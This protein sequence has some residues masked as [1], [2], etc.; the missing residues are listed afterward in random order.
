MRSYRFGLATIAALLCVAPAL[1]PAE[2]VPGDT[3]CPRAAPGLAAFSAAT[4]GPG[5]HDLA[6]IGAA[7]R[8]AAEEYQLCIGEAT[9]RVVDEPR[10]NYDRVKAAYFLLVEARALAAS[11]DTKTALQ[12]AQESRKLAD[13]VATWQPAALGAYQNNNG[14]GYAD[15]RTTDH[16]GSAYQPDA[17]AVL[18]GDTELLNTL[19]ARPQAQ[20]GASPQP[21]AAV[22][23]QVQPSPHP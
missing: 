11:G 15:T 13:F 14:S 2:A 6:K 23:P 10:I 16:N 17:K 18:A 12:A 9:T 5:Q 7:A 19:T 22:Q 8:Q 21:G 20:S 4:Q 3:Y 1:H